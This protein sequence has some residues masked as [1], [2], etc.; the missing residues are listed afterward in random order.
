MTVKKP[1]ANINDVELRDWSK[2]SRFAARIARIGPLVG[3]EQLGVQLQIL[4]PG[5]AA[6]PRHAHHVNE[7]M[8]IVLEGE[9]TYR[10]GDQ[11]WATRT[12]DVISAPAGTGETAHQ[13]T[14]TSD[15]ELKFLSISTRQDP[16][17]VEYPDSGK[18]AVMSRVPKDGGGLA[19]ALRFI[20]KAEDS[21]GYWDGEPGTEDGE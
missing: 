21:L 8:F 11:T 3:A 5:K 7:E 2:G 4:A 10:A 1:I 15:A 12:G 18:F 9:G 14:N 16:E 19:A 13:I 17:V 6:Y 20:G